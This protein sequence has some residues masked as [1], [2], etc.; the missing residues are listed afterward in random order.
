[1]ISVC[2]IVRNEENNIKG[3]IDNCLPYLK[4]GDELVIFDGGS[5][6]NTIK[7]IEEYSD[8]KLRLVKNKQDFKK[9]EW[10]HEEEIRNRAWNQCDNNWILSLDADES[11]SPEFYKNIRL[12][13]NCNPYVNAFHFPTINFINSTK[14]MFNLQVW[15]DYH[16]R[17][18]NREFYSWVGKIHASLWLYG[19]EPITTMDR[20]SKLLDYFL[21]HY[22]RVKGNVNR[23]YGEVPDANIVEFNGFNPRSEFDD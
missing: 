20:R 14:T 1:M 17:L 18:A 15:P 16:I 8:D 21:Y 22:A 4:D 19:K 11:Y 23:I 10:V 7:I 5:T 2:S 6:D 13:I 9:R 12:I 3:M